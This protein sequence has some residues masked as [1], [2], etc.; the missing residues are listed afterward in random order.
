MKQADLCTDNVIHEESVRKVAEKML[1]PEV[2][3]KASEFFRVM[4]TETRFKILYA[5]NLSELCVCDIAVLLGMSKSAIS[6]QLAVLRDAKLVR[7]RRDGKNVF[8]SLAD[9]HVHAMLKGCVEH[10]EED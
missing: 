9:D 6:H 8:Y 7:S 4:G 3:A 10:A 2:F 5:L 1:N